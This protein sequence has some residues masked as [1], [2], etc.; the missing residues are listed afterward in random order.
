VEII[1]RRYLKGKTERS[2]EIE[3]ERAIAEIAHTIYSLRREA[4]LTQQELAQLAGTATSVIDHFEQGDCQGCTPRLL[5]RIIAAVAP[6]SPAK[7]D[8]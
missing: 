2:W 4:G 8:A 5:R 7:E 3:N 6:I 1:R